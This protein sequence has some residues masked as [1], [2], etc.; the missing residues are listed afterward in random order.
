MGSNGRLTIEAVCSNRIVSEVL[1]REYRSNVGRFVQLLFVPPL[2]RKLYNIITTEERSEVM[3]W[4]VLGLKG[5][6]KILPSCRFVGEVILWPRRRR[7]GEDS[8]GGRVREAGR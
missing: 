3:V 7:R 1:C 6:A 8:D 2:S 5:R 4:R